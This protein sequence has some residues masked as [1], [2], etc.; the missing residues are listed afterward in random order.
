MFSVANEDT[1]EVKKILKL[2]QDSEFDFSNHDWY[3]FKDATISK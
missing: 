3:M 2:Q 1:E